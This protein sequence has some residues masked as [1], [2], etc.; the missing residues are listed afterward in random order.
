M[1]TEKNQ[2]IKTRL[3]IKNKNRERYNLPE[4]LKV[5]PELSKYLKPN[6]NGEDSVDFHNPTAIKLLNTALLNYYYGIKH[7]DFPDENLCPPIPGRADYLHYVADLLSNYS[8]DIPKGKKITC[9]DIGIGASAIYPIIGVTEYDWNF[10][11]SDVDTKSLASA[12]N[13]IA[14]N[15]QLKGRVNCILQKDHA[16]FFNGIISK[17]D[18]I[19]ITIC[20]PPFHSSREQAFNGN[21]K[22]VENLT[23]KRP[24]KQVLNFSGLN[25]ELLYEGG[26]YNFIQSMIY[27]SKKYAE[28]CF[29]FTSL[30]SKESNLKGLYKCI[31]KIGAIQD[32]TIPMGTGNKST[33]IIAWTFLTRKEQENWRKNRW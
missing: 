8:D 26:E 32:K 3:H 6:I 17:D 13:I 20:N 15:D 12:K 23:G 33:R 5:T 22:K 31:D 28:N 16:S 14:H 29:W 10:I 4:L 24:T 30:V 2:L 18:R 1:S 21:R 25:S 19:D 7:W 9:L 11:G 27:E